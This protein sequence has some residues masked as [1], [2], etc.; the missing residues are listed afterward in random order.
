MVLPPLLKEQEPCHLFPVEELDGVSDREAF[1]E[2]IMTR[3]GYP[4]THIANE[5]LAAI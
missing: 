5:N 1:R 4:I 3:S 2:S